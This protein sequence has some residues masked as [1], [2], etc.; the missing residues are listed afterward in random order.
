MRSPD[1]FLM[2]TARRLMSTLES[3]PYTLLCGRANAGEAAG[4]GGSAARGAGAARRVQ[5]ATRANAVAVRLRSMAPPW[6]R[7]P[8][9][10]ASLP[11]A[12]KLGGPL[13][14]GQLRV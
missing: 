6:V 5:A 2:T 12:G 3:V 11:S 1:S 10:A 7:R 14:Y 8:A 4:E 13:Q 9:E